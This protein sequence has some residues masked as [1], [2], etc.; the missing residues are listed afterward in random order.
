VW[1]PVF[2]AAATVDPD[3]VVIAVPIVALHLLGLPLGILVLIRVSA[4]SFD[5]LRAL[6]RRVAAANP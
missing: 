1:A 4:R 6:R 2:V 3:A 5:A